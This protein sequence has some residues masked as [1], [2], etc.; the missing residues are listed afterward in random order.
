MLTVSSMSQ[1][2]FARMNERIAE[3]ENQLIKYKDEFKNVPNF[4]NILCDIEDTVNKSLTIIQTK[5]I[6]K[7]HKI[8]TNTEPHEYQLI[9][10]DYQQHNHS[11]DYS[12][13]NY[14]R[15]NKRRYQDSHETSM[16]D[17]YNS[18]HIFK[19]FRK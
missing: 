17:S 3:S 13:Q 6:N 4:N 9:T 15:N 14:F 12:P 1:R 7:L 19:L 2:I 5:N 10:R 8:L 16:Q 11:P 18:Q